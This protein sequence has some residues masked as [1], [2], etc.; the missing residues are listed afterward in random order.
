[1]L[2]YHSLRPE[3]NDLL[4]HLRRLYCNL[5]ISLQRKI[6]GTV[7]QFFTTR[8]GKLLVYHP[9]PSNWGN[10]FRVGKWTFK[11]IPLTM[12]CFV[13]TGRLRHERERRVGGPLVK[14]PLLHLLHHHH[15][16]NATINVA[17]TLGWMLVFPKNKTDSQR[18]STTAF[19]CGANGWI[20]NFP[21]Q[22]GVQ[23]IYIF[24]T[25]LSIT[26]KTPP[27]RPSP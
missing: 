1:M 22:G 8:S 26:S 16:Q 23:T 27:L 25:P 12:R 20:F 13:E 2:V 11:V 15:H 9:G 10:Y 21:N 7:L 17:T 14:V 18:I 5:G 19:R 6:L 3:C 4:T 24:S